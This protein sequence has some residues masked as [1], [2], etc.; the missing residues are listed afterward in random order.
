LIPAG[1]IWFLLRRTK[2]QVPVVLRSG[3]VLAIVAAAGL[4]IT[5]AGTFLG[6]IEVVK[7]MPRFIR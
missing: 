5:I 4:L 1:L 3:K 7:D 2:V 6:Y